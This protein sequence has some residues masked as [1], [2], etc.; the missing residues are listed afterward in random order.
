METVNMYATSM[1]MGKALAT[2]RMTAI[3]CENA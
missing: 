2:R 1:R 3:L